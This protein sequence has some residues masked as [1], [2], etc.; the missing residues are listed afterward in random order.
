MPSRAPIAIL[1][2]FQ[3]QLIGTWKNE[4][5]GHDNQ[6]LPVGG[7]A[8]PLSYNIMPLPQISDPDGYILKNFS[9]T[10]RLHFNDDQGA[11]TLAI[12]AR[13]P[14]RGGQ[15]NQDARAV[16]YEQQVRFAQGPQGP[17]GSLADP[18]NKKVGVGD[19]IHVENG[20][21]LWFPRYVQQSGPYP[22]N[23]PGNIV[24]E[25]LQQ[26]LDSLIGKQISVPHGNS[27]LALGCMDTVPG[28]GGAG[29]WKGDH[30]IQ[31]SPVIPDAAPPFPI[32]ADPL[33]I[34]QG[35]PI[36][37]TLTSELNA[38]QRYS[39]VRLSSP[40]DPDDFENPSPN[41][42]VNPNLPIQMAVMTIKPDAY[43]HWSVTTR[44]L[45]NGQDGHGTVTNIPFEQRAANVVAYTA[46][47]WML[48]KGNDKYLTYTQTILMV[49]VVKAR[50]YVFP[51]LTCNTVKYVGAA[52]PTGLP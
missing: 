13:A 45:T 50:K 49:L 26:P 18:N 6:G 39:T 1:S 19:V 3:Q 22:S 41:F 51:H 2:P 7:I 32:P 37:A 43:M 47:Y 40:T 14:N 25:A 12:A 24:S 21:W 5:F 48:F 31:G 52:V 46:E 20:A 8:N 38:D 11:A 30:L 4:D 23:P 28:K 16:F 15:V 35:A 9:Y 33:P 44:P 34:A 42:T 10:E 17:T 29:P 27:I 36:P